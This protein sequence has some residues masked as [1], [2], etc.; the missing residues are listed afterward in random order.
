MHCSEFRKLNVKKYVQ[1]K[2]RL[3]LKYL[4]YFYSRSKKGQYF[5]RQLTKAKTLFYIFSLHCGRYVERSEQTLYMYTLA[6]YLVVPSSTRFQD[7]ACTRIQDPTNIPTD[8][9][10]IKRKNV[11]IKSYVI[12]PLMWYNLDSTQHQPYTKLNPMNPIQ[13]GTNSFLITYLI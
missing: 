4:P 5:F 8:Y 6:K 13:N 2:T 1:E 3:N 11:L 9:I 12:M 7:T 10:N